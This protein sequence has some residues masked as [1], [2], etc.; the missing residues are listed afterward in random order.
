MPKEADRLKDKAML[1]IVGC[2]N[3]FAGFD[4]AA[5]QET[6]TRTSITIKSSLTTRTSK[7]KGMVAGQEVA[8]LD[9][10]PLRRLHR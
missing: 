5:S 8:L 6:I 10:L 2:N 4:P 1:A 7:F 3:H 9:L